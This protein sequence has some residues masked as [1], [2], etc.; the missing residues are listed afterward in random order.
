MDAIS[1]VKEAELSADKL[2]KDAENEV[3]ESAAKAQADLEALLEEKT[4][5]FK[6]AGQ[7]LIEDA[8]KRGEE[9]AAPILAKGRE[10]SEKITNVGKETLENAVKI[11]V[12]RI[13][14]K[15]GNS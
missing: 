9:E 6:N 15:N 7:S 11:I 13:V 5:E 4:K 8:I 14:N 2:I 1:V 10:D 12:E 3:R